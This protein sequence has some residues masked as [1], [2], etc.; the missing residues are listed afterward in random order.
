M[1]VQGQNALL[2]MHYN[3]TTL[4]LVNQFISTKKYSPFLL[5]DFGI[6]IVQ[7]RTST[8]E[9]RINNERLKQTKYYATSDD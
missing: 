2:N 8:T 4:S 3:L 9:I 1:L 7:S 5:I 6:T